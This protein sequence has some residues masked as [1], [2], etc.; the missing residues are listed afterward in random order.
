MRKAEAKCF[1]FMELCYSLLTI[2][3]TKNFQ[4][5]L[6]NDSLLRFASFGIMVKTRRRIDF[7]NPVLAGYGRIAY[8][9]VNQEVNA[10]QT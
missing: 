7:Q 10:T 5:Q 4:I 1:G 9:P 3:T 8:L 2:Q 6:F